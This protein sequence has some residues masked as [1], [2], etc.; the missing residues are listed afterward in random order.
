L[1]PA[2]LDQSSG[3]CPAPI[4]INYSVL[5][6]QVGVRLNQ[7]R[8]EQTPVGFNLLLKFIIIFGAKP[9]LVRIRHYVI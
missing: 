4:P 1:F 9:R 2:L 3:V 6:R 5:V 8:F 7:E